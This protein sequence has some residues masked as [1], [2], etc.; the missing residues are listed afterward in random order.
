MATP[1]QNRTTRLLG[2]LFG[3]LLCGSNA[4][5]L[6]QPGETA[7]AVAEAPAQ[8]PSVNM[9]VQIETRGL[10]SAAAEAAEGLRLIAQSL[11]ELANRQD[12]TPE[13]NAHIEL[14]P[15]LSMISA[16]ERIAGTSAG[17]C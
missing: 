16:H 13:E 14:A 2:I 10:E 1:S 8:P 12:L 7:S 17:L 15:N 5:A 3:A 6:A 4:S 9:N 11:Q